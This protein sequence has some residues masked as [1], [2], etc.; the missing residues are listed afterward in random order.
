MSHLEKLPNEKIELKWNTYREGF[1]KIKSEEPNLN[2]F[3]NLDLIEVNNSIWN[4]NK[5]IDKLLIKKVGNN[6]FL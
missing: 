4:I 5:K 2:Y 6:Q 1:K 3:A